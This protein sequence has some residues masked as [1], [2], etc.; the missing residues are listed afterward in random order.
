TTLF[1]S[2]RRVCSIGTNSSSNVENRKVCGV[3]ESTSASTEDIGNANLLDDKIQGYPKIKA[4][5]LIVPIV[6]RDAAKCPP[7][8]KPITAILSLS[9][10]HSSAFC[11][12]SAIASSASLKT[13]ENSSPSPTEYRST[14]ALLPSAKKDIATRSASRSDTK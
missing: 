3:D 6:A 1:R 4:S 5:G 12:M 14:K 10:L 9:T 2:N 11:W 13:D 8:E 7:A